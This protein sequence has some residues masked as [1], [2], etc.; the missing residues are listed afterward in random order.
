MNLASLILAAVRD[1][2]ELRIAVGTGDPMTLRTMVD[3]AL[4]I[5]DV[6]GSSGLGA[7]ARVMHVG[8]NSLPYV[9]FW[10]AAQLAG[11]EVALV[12]PEYPVDLIDDAV[13]DFRPDAYAF[14]DSRLE[15]SDGMMSINYAGAMDGSIT[16][17]GVAG[18]GGHEWSPGTSRNELDPACLMLTSGTSGP[19]KLCVQSHRYFIELGRY[20]A[21][22]FCLSP[23]DV[24][25]APLPLFH[26]NPMGYGLLAAL[27]GRADFVSAPRFSASGFW[28]MVAQHGGTVLIL[29]GPP[30]Q[31]L[32]RATEPVPPQAQ[33]RAAFLV[34]EEFLRRFDV[35]LGVSG[36]GSTEFG[37]LTHTR[38]W[39]RG[40][41][42]PVTEGL[43]NLAGRSRRD[44]EWRLGQ[45]GEIELRQLRQGIFLSG[46]MR[47]GR[48]EP[49][50]SEDGWIATGD[51]G[52]E[53]DGELVF[54]ERMSESV[55]HRGEFVPLAYLDDVFSRLDGMEEASVW[56]SPTDPFGLAIFAVGDA[57]LDA[58]RDAVDSLPRFMRPGHLV[59]LARLPRDKGVGK[60]QRRLLLGEPMLECQS[61]DRPVG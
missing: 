25:V 47:Q 53:H 29:H 4:S 33:V 41:P 37:G 39:R 56:T 18:R 31:I 14:E 16:V 15:P 40:E 26:I 59:R 2:P 9:T 11:L 13:A 61:L 48:V 10:M 34:N 50:P 58:V 38:L 51:R 60:V 5:A 45:Q 57:H 35:P 12:N 32:L 42:V 46:Y 49:V 6:L 55:R 21:D 27:S 8:D 43:T 3:N 36:Y 24:V 17:D 1:R 20:V 52:R 54:V 22:T 44:V 7:G 23:R 30:S 19:P 28:P